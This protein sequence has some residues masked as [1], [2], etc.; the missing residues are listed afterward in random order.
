MEPQFQVDFNG[1]Q[2]QLQDVNRLGRLALTDDHVFTELFRLA[3]KGASVSRGVL[4]P[5]SDPLVVANGATG[6]IK[7]NPH[8][9]FI[10]SLT[11]AGTDALKNY[12]DVR[13]SLTVHTGDT[14]LTTTIT[15]LAN[16]SGQDR[17]DLV[18]TKV[19]I[20]QS[21]DV[22]FRK[23]KSP[24]S[25]VVTDTPV[26]TYVQTTTA[27]GVVV[28]TPGAPPAWPTIISDADPVY[29]IPLAYVLVPNGFGSGS[30]VTT[31]NQIAPLMRLAQAVGATNYS[32]ATCHQDPTWRGTGTFLPQ[33]S[34]GE[35]LFFW[36]G[37]AVGGVL[38]SRDWRGRLA[39]WTACLG[40]PSLVW[41]GGSYPSGANRRFSLTAANSTVTFGVGQSF[42][43]DSSGRAFIAALDDYEI[44]ATGSPHTNQTVIYVDMSDGQL[45][46]GTLSGSPVYSWFV[47]INFGGKY[48]L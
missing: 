27:F 34:G 36:T 41:S 43:V 30:T 22:Q 10:G 44:T 40:D 38:D 24:T 26:P 12:Q 42:V 2:I 3:P 20:D 8:R 4:P 7:V 1:Q 25:G 9:A 33:I 18:Y 48:P 5:T 14:S 16:S 17:W 28:G 45:K 35:S 13:S 23:I 47:W 11:A 29:Y 15:L 6:S 21:F 19:L 39:T 37:A 46:V 32:T 31:I